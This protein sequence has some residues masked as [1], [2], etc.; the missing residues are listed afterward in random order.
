MSGTFE[1]FFKTNYREVERR[2]CAAGARPDI[3]TE[4]TQEA[5]TRAY[6]RGW[7]LR[8]YDNPAAWVQKV[9]FNHR[10]DLE[11]RERR[12]TELVTAFVVEPGDPVAAD[13]RVA[14]AVDTLP[15]QQQAAVR[16]FYGD[17]MST[18]EAAEEMGISSGTVRFHLTQARRNLRPLLS[19]GTAAQEV[20]R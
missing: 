2:V 6:Q 1:D 11:R 17:G 20:S 8:S 9:A 5:F 13:P 4:A 10:I 3:A 16:A 7:R 19:R 18:E 14:P 12:Q 15:P